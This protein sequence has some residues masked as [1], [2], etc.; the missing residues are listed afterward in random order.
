MKKIIL[1]GF[2][3]L[4]V[5]LACQLA[6]ANGTVSG[7]VYNEDGTIPFSNIRVI[8][9]K[10]DSGQWSASATTD[11]LGHY[12]FSLPAGDYK[13]RAGDNNDTYAIEYYNGKDTWQGADRVSVQDGQTTS[14]INFT[15][16]IG[17]Q[18][19]GRVYLEDG[20][21]PFAY[22]ATVGICKSSGQ[23]IDYIYSIYTKADGRYQLVVPTGSYKIYAE[24]RLN[25]G[26]PQE[27]SYPQEYY[28]NTYH[29]LDAET[30][31]VTSG[32]IVDGKDFILTPGAYI[33]GYVRNEASQPVV[34]C[35][36]EAIPTNA[37]EERRWG[38]FSVRTNDEG[39]YSR[40]VP[41]E[42]PFDNY[43]VSARN[44]IRYIDNYYNN[45]LTFEEADI[46][47]VSAQGAQNINFSLKTGS[48][49]SGRVFD[50]QQQPINIQNA[51]I[52]F[53]KIG[54]SD[55]EKE[56]NIHPDGSYS[57]GGLREGIYS[58]TVEVPA[59]T[60]YAW[61]EKCIYT[62]ES[63]TI[64]NFDFYL[65]E[66]ALLAGIFH[67]THGMG[68]SNI[69]YG[70]YGEYSQSLGGRSDA[71]G[72]YQIRLKPGTWSIGTSDFSYAIIPF[73]VEV[74]DSGEIFQHDFEVY[75]RQTGALASGHINMG[76][77]LPSNVEF[78]IL[79]HLPQT[80]YNID[81]IDALKLVSGNFVDSQS[82]NYEIVL[83]PFGA[84]Q[85]SLIA[86]YSRAAIDF[87]VV[88]TI[89][90]ARGGPGFDFDFNQTAEIT[91]TV[92]HEGQPVFNAAV[93]LAEYVNEKFKAVAHTDQ[94]GVYHIY[95]VSAGNYVI[96]AKIEDSELRRRILVTDVIDRETRQVDISFPNLAP[97]IDK[98][99]DMTMKEGEELH[100]RVNAYD[101]DSEYVHFLLGPNM[102]K[103]AQ[104][105]GHDDYA[106]LIFKPDFNDA[107]IYRGITVSAEDFEGLR[108]STTFTLTV[109]NVNRLPKITEPKNGTIFEVRAGQNINFLVKAYDPDLVAPK[110]MVRQ[111]PQGATFKPAN[112]IL[113]QGW[114]VYEFKWTPTSKQVQNELYRLVFDAYDPE[115][116]KIGA[117]DTIAVYIKVNKSNTPPRM[118]YLMTLC[119]RYFLWC[120]WDKEDKWWMLKYSYKVDNKQWSIPTTRTWIS[121]PE[122]SAG[123]SPGWHTFYVKAIDTDGA[124]SAPD[125]IMF[126]KAKNR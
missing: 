87:T 81:N 102:P 72:N 34:N 77:T 10:Y 114:T 100:I 5:A 61:Q 19:K 99:Q 44:D 124:E 36:I 6:Y 41:Y 66:G 14:N 104:A 109:K 89:E 52:Y 96:S 57:V 116:G 28:N 15:L 29:Y 112:I 8:V 67:D 125:A 108:S 58:A 117:Q 101:P 21:T 43:V 111:L 97:V 65:Q 123:L 73:V 110:L 80:N 45:K 90:D 118:L 53:D 93:V 3:V 107:G 20:T 23:H 88:D 126:F 51:K 39:F 56:T 11:S 46:V 60:G 13:V 75:D 121:I 79:S 59:D 47:T 92:T 76:A 71:N 83:P 82:Y 62:P 35:Y 26:T 37:P 103:F 91:G 122:I 115:S 17:A 86:F 40:L 64:N 48:V 7:Y 63:T 31:T 94:N 4:F 49:V 106:E 68:I 16:A 30:I 38:W 42:Q 95:C 1:I 18:I 22:Y 120:G 54:H 84:Y 74:R 33:S 78:V 119:N 85:L 50:P 105:I 113:A 55:I 27:I 12:Q 25:Y 98:I 2:L 9:N 32:D 70:F 24:G 69:N